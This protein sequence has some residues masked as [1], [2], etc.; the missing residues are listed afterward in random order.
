MNTLLYFFAVIGFI[1]VMYPLAETFV[2]GV[3][4]YIKGRVD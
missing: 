1:T 4:Y 3:M 2:A